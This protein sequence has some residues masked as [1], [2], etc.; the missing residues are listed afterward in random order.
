VKLATG[1]TIFVRQDQT[2]LDALLTN[3]ISAPHSCRIGR[4]GT[5]EVKVVAGEIAH[6]DSFLT[7]EQKSSQTCMLT[8]VSRAKSEHLVIQLE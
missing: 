8:C 3:G 1:A 2:L 7:V 6:H 5:C 4:C